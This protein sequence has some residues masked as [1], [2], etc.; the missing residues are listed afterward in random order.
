MPFHAPVNADGSVV[1][2]GH[3]GNLLLEAGQLREEEPI[4]N[5]WCLC[6]AYCQKTQGDPGQPREN[7]PEK[8][9][10]SIL[11]TAVMKPK[12]AQHSQA[13]LHLLAQFTCLI[14]LF[15]A[16]KMAQEESQHWP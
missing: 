6:Q 5:V 8:T 11:S 14:Y 1:M 16:R 10:S 4:S 15:I 2:H 3:E 12:A 7:I 9:A 13:S